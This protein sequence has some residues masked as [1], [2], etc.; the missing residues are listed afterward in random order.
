MQY[1]YCNTKGQLRKRKII[2]FAQESHIKKSHGERKVVGNSQD[3]EIWNLGQCG[4]D[5][6]REL[7]VLQN[8][9]ARI[10]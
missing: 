10:K 9:A 2:K 8:P 6:S 1:A 5:G 4:R 3:L 7:V